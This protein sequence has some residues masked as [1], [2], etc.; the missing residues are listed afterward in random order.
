MN[1]R[2]ASPFAHAKQARVRL[3][4]AQ[5]N[6]SRH[7]A[8]VALGESSGSPIEDA[9]LALEQ[10]EAA[11]ETA[12][13]TREALGAEARV[14]ENE[15]SFASS[16]LNSAVR[17]VLQTSSEVRQLLNDLEIARRSVADLVAQLR[18][19]PYGA[20]PDHFWDARTVQASQDAD[21]AWRAAIAA[22]RTDADAALPTGMTEWA[23]WPQHRCARP[24]GCDL[25]RGGPVG[26]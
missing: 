18:A 1:V 19:L 12:K 14:A 5:A 17:D 22:L 10:A 25:T 23:H 2:Q 24:R 21:A 8:A 15:M 13:R 3:A 7:L 11:H 20:V 6:E 26:G 9:K 16:H 4:E